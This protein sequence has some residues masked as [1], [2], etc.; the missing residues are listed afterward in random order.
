MSSDAFLREFRCLTEAGGGFEQLRGLVLQ[1][2][3]MGRLVSQDPSDQPV[4]EQLSRIRAERTKPSFR[5]STRMQREM[6]ANPFEVP[7]GWGWASLNDVAVFINGDRSKNYPSK[8]HQVAKGIPFINAGHLKGGRIDL[9]EM[10]YITEERFELLRSGKVQ[11]GDLL[12]CLRGSLGKAAIV[13]GIDR[14]AI[15]SSLLI[16]RPVAGL[17]FAKYLL[18]YFASFLGRAMILRYD[19]GTAQPNL[20][21]ADVAKY[22]V[23]LP[24][25]PEQK[26]I[27]AKVDQL[28]ALCDDL[29]AKQTKKRDLATQSTRSALTALTTAETADDLAAAWRRVAKNFGDVLGDVQGILALKDAVLALAVRGQIEN[30]APGDESIEHV[31]DRLSL[32]RDALAAKARGNHDALPEVED[33]PFEVARWRW[34]R[35]GNLAEIVGGVAKGRKL[36]GRQVTSFP[37]L[38]VANV[39]RGF[40][41]LTLMKELEIPSEELPRYRLFPNDVLFTEGG[42][43]DKL[44]RSAVWPGEID[45]CIHQNHIFR[46]RLLTKDVDPRWVSMFCNSPVGRAY[47]EDAAKQTTNLAT[48][49][50]TELRHCPI[51][52]P[53]PQEQRRILDRLHQITSLLD[54]LEAKLRKQ[55][56]TATRLAESLAVAVAA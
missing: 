18:H 27:V 6:V 47:F 22:A 56:E 13:D 25:L 20:S 43:W 55:E 11:R 24:P 17:C 30:A 45:P 23:P 44:G 19:N 2:G 4:E 39:Q 5:S 14:G 29:E 16:V 21:A 54:D 26:R 3:I 49:N 41:D 40:L 38:R 28:M 34:I 8:P 53:P 36:A 9:G 1:L 32:A 31:T 51:P 33:A 12:Y 35:L 50:M 42:D 48:I 46:A 10:N 15:A 37:Y 52:V 7:R